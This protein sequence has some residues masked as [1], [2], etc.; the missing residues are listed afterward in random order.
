MSLRAF[1]LFFIAV[2]V[3]LAAFVA[4]WAAGQYQQGHQIIYVITA[5]IAFIASAGLVV[6]AAMFQR[7][8]KHLTAL[9]LALVVPRI[10][11]ACPVCFGNSDAPMAK[12]INQG[13][14]LMLVVVGFMLAAF[15]SFFISLVR[16]ARLAEGHDPAPQSSAEP[17][18]GIV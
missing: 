5:V 6:Y 10:A 16:R 11:L 4:A 8:T 7:K 18:E 14:L 3:V 12:A 9:L 2:S 15:A 1:H 17:Q 13:V